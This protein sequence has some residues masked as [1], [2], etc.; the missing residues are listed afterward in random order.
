ME[1]ARPPTGAPRGFINRVTSLGLPPYAAW[2]RNL[3]AK[4]MYRMSPA[5]TWG[6]YLPKEEHKMENIWLNERVR[7]KVKSAGDNQYVQKIMKYPY[8]RTGVW[9][10]DALDHWVQVPHVRGAQFEIEKDGGMDNF[11]LRRGGQELRSVY[12]ERLRRNILGRQRE[13]EKNFLLQKTAERL[14]TK[15]MKE[16]REEVPLS[17]NEGDFATSSPLSEEDGEKVENVLRKYGLSKRQ[18]ASQA[19]QLR[20][21]LSARM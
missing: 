15:I 20:S 11:I 12:G 1:T 9:F 10:S 6:Q 2:T 7:I 19:E 17:E 18:V 3:D 14:A 8:T 21:S 16:I 4:A 13:I 5:H